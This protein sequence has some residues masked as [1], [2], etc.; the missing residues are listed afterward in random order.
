MKAVL[1]KEF[2]ENLLKAVIETALLS[3]IAA[4]L[5]PFGYKIL[6][7]LETQIPMVMQ[8]YGELFAKL[9]NLNFFI[10]SQWFGK[11]LLELAILFAIINGIGIIAG[12]SERKTA[13]FLFSKPISRRSIYCAKIIVATVY[14]V[15]PI[16]ISTFLI[17]LFAKTVP[18]HINYVLFLKLLAESIFASSLT[19]V[20]SGAVSIVID[21]RI[22]GGFILVVAIIGAV[23]LSKIKMFRFLNYTLLFTGDFA[24]SI[25]FS[26]VGIALLVIL[27]IHLIDRKEF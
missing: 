2:K 18:Q 7:S 5:I 19:V 23:F 3:G 1:K 12:E 4:T 27:S 10:V 9:K 14:T 20:L 11:N 16:A 8:K 13:I 15:V 21:D 17:L 22:K 24:R 26:L 25:T 6:G